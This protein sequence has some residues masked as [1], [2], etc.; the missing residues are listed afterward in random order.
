MKK[1]LWNRVRDAIADGI[2]AT[3][4]PGLNEMTDRVLAAIGDDRIIDR[5]EVVENSQ[6]E[7]HVRALSS[8]GAVVL[9]SELYENREWALEVADDLGVPVTFSAAA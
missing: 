3:Q 5:A 8:N 4:L 1:Q 6:G 7:Y 9:S 2:D